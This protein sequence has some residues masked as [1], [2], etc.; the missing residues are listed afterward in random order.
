MAEQL[1]N[2][3][4][5]F[6]GEV[7]QSHCHHLLR[8]I[9]EFDHAL[10]DP[11]ARRVGAIALAVPAVS[12]QVDD[13]RV[14]G[15]R[16]QRFKLRQQGVFRNHVPIREGDHRAEAAGDKAALILDQRAARVGEPVQ[17]REGGIYAVRAVEGVQDRR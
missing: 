14:H 13:E 11:T 16:L 15:L 8:I 17:K 1:R 4:H 12:E 6:I 5:L 2:V 9:G 10:D 7:L 3:G